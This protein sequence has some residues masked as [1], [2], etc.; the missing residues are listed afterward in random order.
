M[1]YDRE[2]LKV[3]FGFS[4]FGTEEIALT[5]FSVTDPASLTFDAA[6]ALAEIDI[7]VLG[8]QLEVEM[9][10]L[11]NSAN[12][13]W[14]D[15]SRINYVRIA[16]VDTTGLEIGDPKIHDDLTPGA[17]N[18]AEVLPQSSIVASLRS[19]VKTG[20]ANYGKMYLPHTVMFLTANTPHA[21]PTELAAFLG[22][23]QVFVNDCNTHFDAQ[24]TQSVFISNLSKIGT[25]TTKKVAEVALGDV[26]DTQRRRRNKLPELYQFQ[27]IP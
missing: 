9:F 13:K 7:S 6:A 26:N 23:F 8:P 12:M 14:A 17:G 3:T 20:T 19:G 25:G 24:V 21:S 22:E 4:I 5:G 18:N 10:T 15:Y 2:F 16:A 27:D 1:P 11:L